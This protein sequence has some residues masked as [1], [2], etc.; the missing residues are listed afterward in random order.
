MGVDS[1]DTFVSFV[2]QNRP[3]KLTIILFILFYEETYQSIVT[4]FAFVSL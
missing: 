2:C 1:C 3:V 4:C